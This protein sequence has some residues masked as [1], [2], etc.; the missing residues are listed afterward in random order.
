MQRCRFR[1]LRQRRRFERSQRGP[2]TSRDGGIGPDAVY[3]AA[4]RVASPTATESAPNFPGIAS[5]HALYIKAQL[6][7]WKR[8]ARAHD[9]LGLI[10]AVSDG[11]TDAEVDALAAY[12]A[13]QPGGAPASPKN[14][15]EVSAD[16]IAG[17]D[18][19][20]GE[21]AHPVSSRFVGN[22]QACGNGHS[23]VGRLAGLAP[24]YTAKCA[25]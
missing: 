16:G 19:H 21:I 2:P 5:Q 14:A 20:T 22:H 9:P 23:H 3:R 4:D 25:L 17:G 15:P 10:N 18:V 6:L 11:L 8:G 13:A 7:A 24:L 1:R 12:Y